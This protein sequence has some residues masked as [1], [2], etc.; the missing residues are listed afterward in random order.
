MKINVSNIGK[1]AN[2]PLSE[3][4]IKK[5]E[6]QL[7]E[8]LQY[9]EE[10]KEVDTQNITPTS[11]VTGLENVLREDVASES[12]SQKD[13]LSNAKSINKGFFQVKGILENQ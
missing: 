1:L 9:I 12:L 8:T 4:E 2:L 5:F 13:A 6:K 3:E 7:I 11:Q 10:L